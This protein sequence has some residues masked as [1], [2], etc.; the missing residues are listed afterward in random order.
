[1][2][3]YPSLVFDICVRPGMI[4]KLLNQIMQELIPYPASYKNSVEKKETVQIEEDYFGNHQKSPPSL[5]LSF[6]SA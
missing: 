4:P 5:K 1:M 2:E 6:L 3:E